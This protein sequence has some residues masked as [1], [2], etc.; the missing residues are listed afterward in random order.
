MRGQS[1]QP[2]AMRKT[3][4]LLALAL[5]VEASLLSLAH[6]Q[7]R[8]YHQRLNEQAEAAARPPAVLAGR[9]LP[10]VAALVQQPNPQNPEESGWRMLA[11]LQASGSLVVV[12]RGYALPRWQPNGSPDF[13]GLQ[14]P[15]G[16]QQLAGV[17]VPIPTR[18]GWLRG[19]DT[20]TSPQLLAFLNPAVLTSQTVLPQ[21]FIL[22]RAETL[23][24]VP[25]P[26]APPTANPLRHLSY[27]IQWLL[28]AAVFPL[29]CGVSWG[30]GWR[31]MGR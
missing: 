16:P 31:R 22:T 12:D 25:T 19:P 24:T 17:W 9:Y 10:Q 26:S 5:L 14:P 11:L 21:Q 18:K 8:R 7:W 30:V 2:A 27:M 4:L 3:I 20:T 28:M 29:L 1:M 13:T 6:W 15:P 23:A